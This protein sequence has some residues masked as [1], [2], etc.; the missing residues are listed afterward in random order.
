MGPRHARRL[1]DRGV[2]RLARTAA[3]GPGGAVLRGD[4]ADRA[5]VRDPGGG[6]AAATSTRSSGTSTSNS[7]L[8]AR[9]ASAPRRASWPTRSSTRR[10]PACWH[11]SRSTRGRT[12]GRCGRRSACC[13]RRSGRRTASTGTPAHR[14]VARWLVT[15]LASLA[16]VLPAGFR[17]MPQALAADPRGCPVSRS[18]GTAAGTASDEVARRRV[19]ERPQQRR[20]CSR[21]RSGCSRRTSCIAVPERGR[22]H[23]AARRVEQ[24][25]ALDVDDLVVAA[26][27]VARRS[28]DPGARSSSGSPGA[29]PSDVARDE[30]GGRLVGERLARLVVAD[31]AVEPLVGRLV[32]DEVAQVRRCPPRTGSR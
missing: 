23:P 16:A 1:D 7:A 20:R 3:A 18:S 29:S 11:A 6:P 30:V 21:S 8:A 27:R 17:Q 2:R 15:G 19:V 9:S 10:S 13:R 28:S 12:T 5:R 14:L 4:A 25:A 26:A 32:R 22:A 31:E 24:V